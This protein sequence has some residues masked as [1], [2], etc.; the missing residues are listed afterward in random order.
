MQNIETS[1]KKNS[2]ADFRN[3]KK[4]IFSQSSNYLINFFKFLNFKEIYY[5]RQINSIENEE[6]S[7]DYFLQNGH[8]LFQYYENKNSSMVNK[9]NIEKIKKNNNTVLSFFSKPEEQVENN[10]KQQ[11]QDNQNHHGFRQSAHLL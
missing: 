1:F 11:C 7:A 3:E 2:L 6:E 4:I 10:N 8:T 5:E 9:R